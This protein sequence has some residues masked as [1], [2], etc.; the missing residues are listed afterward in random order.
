MEQ[1]VLTCIVARV[2][3]KE[4]LPFFSQLK[5]CAAPTWLWPLLGEQLSAGGKVLQMHN[6]GQLMMTHVK[7][8]LWRLPSSN[9][10]TGIMVLR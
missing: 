3:P 7:N 2:L 6:K 1:S 8:L 9:L 4:L 5:F 10:V